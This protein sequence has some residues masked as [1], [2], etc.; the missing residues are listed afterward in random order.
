MASFVFEKS[1]SEGGRPPIME[2]VDENG[3][4]VR[5][6][7]YHSDYPGTCVP[8]YAPE[9]NNK[10]K[11]IPYIE[12]EQRQAV[13]I[14]GPSGSGKSTQAA[15]LVVELE[16]NYPKF[17]KCDIWFFT[18]NDKQD[19]AFKKFE[20]TEEEKELARQMELY[21]NMVVDKPPP[22]Q[23]FFRMFMKDKDTQQEMLTTHPSDFQQCVVIFDDWQ[24]QT[25]EWKSWTLA[26]V[27][28]LLT[29]SRTNEVFVIM[30][31]HVTR[32]GPT[33]QT[34]IFECDTYVLFPKF[35]YSSVESFVKD[36]V[37]IKPQQLKPYKDHKGRCIYIRKSFPTFIQSETLAQIL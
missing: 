16:K 27:N 10:L 17:K 5:F 32:Q 26:F 12:D 9:G 31:T 29:H 34:I 25:E 11:N 21:P 28:E 22:P 3:K 13:Y 33:T 18:T 4:H 8:E 19:K 20:R 1:E 6:I 14:S 7:Y 15:N 24:S 36:Y 2:E 23:R 35:N 37:G 30:I